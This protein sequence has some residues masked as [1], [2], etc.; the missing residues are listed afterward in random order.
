MVVCFKSQRGAGHFRSQEGLKAKDVW[1]SSHLLFPPSLPVPEHIQ[2]CWIRSVSLQFRFLPSRVFNISG[3]VPDACRIKPTGFHFFPKTFFPGPTHRQELDSP[4]TVNSSD[5]S[6]QPASPR[7]PRGLMCFPSAHTTND[8]FLTQRPAPQ[9]WKLL[10]RKAVLASALNPTM[11]AGGL[12]SF[13][14][15]LGPGQECSLPAQQALYG[16]L[17]SWWDI[18]QLSGPWP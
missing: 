7:V 4:V 13:L 17:G 1:S 2:F 10:A 14:T 5:Q 15:C 18:S 9:L 11:G 8:I 12:P 6:P 16:Q 3:W